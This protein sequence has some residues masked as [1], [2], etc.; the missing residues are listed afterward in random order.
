M[1]RK[2]FPTHTG[3]EEEQLGSERTTLLGL[4]FIEMRNGK[5]LN[6]Q[7]LI[8]RSG[9]VGI[10]TRTLRHS[11]PNF[12]SP[13][14]FTRKL[15]RYFMRCKAPECPTYRIC[16]VRFPTT[17]KVDTYCLKGRGSLLL[18]TPY[19]VDSTYKN[20]IESI[21]RT[22]HDFSESTHLLLSSPR[23]PDAYCA[24]TYFVGN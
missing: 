9:C 16:T 8:G 10:F 4:P 6:S 17:K 1:F 19:E 20:T 18:L 15:Q 14:S 12:T 3:E 22:A 5:V 2:R 7:Y 13:V 11:T 23:N 24:G 21:L